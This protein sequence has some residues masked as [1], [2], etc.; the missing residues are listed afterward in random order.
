MSSLPNL[1]RLAI[2]APGDGADDPILLSAPTTEADTSS[3]D[4]EEQDEAQQQPQP[5]VEIPDAA[6]VLPS[7]APS[8]RGGRSRDGEADPSSSSSSVEVVDYEASD[9]RVALQVKESG[10]IPGEPGLFAVKDL[11]PNS[12]VTVYTYDRVVDQ[13]S[14]NVMSDSKLDAVNRFAMEGATRDLTLILNIPVNSKHAGAFANEPSKGTN[15]S[16][17]MSL[18]SEKVSLPNGDTWHVVALYTCDASVRA[19]EELL[20]NYGRNYEPTRKKEG[21]EAAKG[22]ASLEPLNPPIE[23]VVARIL[24]TRGEDEGDLEGILYKMDP[25]SS[26]DED[27]DDEAFRPRGRTRPQKTRVLPARVRKQ[28]VQL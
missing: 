24:S 8:P 9:L 28:R 2:G 12:L 7:P 15:Q 1:S 13:A 25:E 17:N 10:V 18:H 4:D 3:S 22:C 5:P 16:S 14:L 21:Y 20:W 6:A 26:S 19:G 11:P 27:S 23:E